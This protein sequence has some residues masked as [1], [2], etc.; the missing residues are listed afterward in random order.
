VRQQEQQREQTFNAAAVWAAVQAQRISLRLLT[1]RDRA[2]EATAQWA[3]LK[4]KEDSMRICYA[5]AG[6]PMQST[7]V[8][9]APDDTLC[10]VHEDS[11]SA[12][13]VADMQ[14]AAA[15]TATAA[16]AVDE[17]TAT[18]GAD[19]EAEAPVKY[20]YPQLSQQQLAE[21]ADAQR[22][23]CGAAVSLQVWEQQQYE[24]QQQQLQQRL[25]HDALRQLLQ[26]RQQS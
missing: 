24:K 19:T 4:Q 13:E 17:A 23:T 14:A 5:A 6:L 11:Y 1:V 7:K 18:A 16:A 12:A 22:D 8:R 21:V 20:K 10:S 2:K 26:Q 9:M 25:Q 15:T 3:L